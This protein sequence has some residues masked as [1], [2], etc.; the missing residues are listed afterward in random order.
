M[1]LR[2][3][4]DNSAARS[5]YEGFGFTEVPG[6]GRGEVGMELSFG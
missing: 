2:M 3:A 1:T 6:D 4:P 5:L